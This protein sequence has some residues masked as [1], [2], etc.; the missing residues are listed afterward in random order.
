MEAMT[1]RSPPPTSRGR[2]LP[3]SS[4]PRLHPSQPVQR[5]KNSLHGSLPPLHFS[6]VGESAV[7]LLCL[8]MGRIIDG[9]TQ[10]PSFLARGKTLI[11]DGA[12][13]AV[14]LTDHVLVAGVAAVMSGSLE[15][16]ALGTD[17]MVAPLFESYSR[18]HV[19]LLPEVDGNIGGNALLVQQVSESASVVGGGRS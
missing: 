10:V 6:S 2:A 12:S 7:P 18:H 3:Q 5:C 8:Q 1:P 17:H 13:L 15:D 11:F 14:L 4:Q 19:G 16:L 9:Q